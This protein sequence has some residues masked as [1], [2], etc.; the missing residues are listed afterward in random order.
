MPNIREIYKKIEALEKI[1]KSQGAYPIMFNN[2]WSQLK[3][4][5]YCKWRKFLKGLKLWEKK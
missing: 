4:I 1:D 3:F 5:Y 2:E